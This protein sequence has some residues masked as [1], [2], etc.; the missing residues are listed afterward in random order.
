MRQQ[1]IWMLE[2]AMPIT[3]ILAVFLL[4]PPILM[5]IVTAWAWAF[6]L[7]EQQIALAQAFF[8]G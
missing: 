1:F 7:M 3:A 2:A 4:V 5:G 6:Y 8:A